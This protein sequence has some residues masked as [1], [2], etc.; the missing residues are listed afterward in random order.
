MTQTKSTTGPTIQPEFSLT[1]HEGETVSE[2]THRGDWPLD[3]FGLRHCPDNCPATLARFG[4]VMDGLGADA[5][6]VTLLFITFDPE[7][8]RVADVDK[9]VSAMHPSIVRLMGSNMEIAEHHH[10]S[11]L[12]LRRFLKTQYLTPIRWGRLL[13]PI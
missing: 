6:K 10:R 11:R 3:F 13:P 4:N 2:K 8:D 1:N 5:S 9:Y 12:S 7:P